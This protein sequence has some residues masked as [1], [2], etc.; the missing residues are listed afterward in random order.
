MRSRHRMPAGV[1]LHAIMPS[2]IIDLMAADVVMQQ[3][4]GE[5]N[6]LGVVG[7]ADP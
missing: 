5:V 1:R 3:A 6:A 7:A 2:W 4:S